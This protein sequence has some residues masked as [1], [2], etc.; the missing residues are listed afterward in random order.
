MSP[1]GFLWRSRKDENPRAHVDFCGRPCLDSSSQA[2]SCR[3]LVGTAPGAQS[4]GTMDTNFGY[5]M[6][7][8]SPG[9]NYAMAVDEYD[10]VVAA[11]ELDGHWVVTR[12][13]ANGTIDTGFGSLGQVLLCTRRVILAR[14]H[15]QKTARRRARTRGRGEPTFLWRGERIGRA[16]SGR[17]V[18]TGKSPFSGMSPRK[19]PRLRRIPG[20][21]VMP[22]GSARGSCR[23]WMNHRV[24]RGAGY[25]IRFELEK[26]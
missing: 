1:R 26:G 22:D 4:P 25:Q 5:V 2:G 10:R 9:R 18:R 8:S 11:G 24:V 6:V 21:A 23:P 19:S 15:G 3:V 7:L 13:N 14:A 20:R 12:V 17:P 16:E